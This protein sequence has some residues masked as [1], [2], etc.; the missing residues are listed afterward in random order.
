MNVWSMHDHKTSSMMTTYHI[1]QLNSTI[2]TYRY[3]ESVNI[4]R[5]VD[6]IPLE[7]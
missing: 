5:E 1:L 4:L 7:A 3:L 6:L 2:D